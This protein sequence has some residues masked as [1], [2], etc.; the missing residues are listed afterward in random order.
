MKGLSRN[1]A[2][3]LV[4]IYYSTIEGMSEKMPELKSCTQKKK[5]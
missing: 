4:K 3:D 2:L 5:K 1:N